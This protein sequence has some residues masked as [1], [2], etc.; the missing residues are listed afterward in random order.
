MNRLYIVTIVLLVVA[1]IFAIQNTSMIALHFLFWSF[2]GSQAFTTILIFTIGFV[3]GWMLE[4]RKV[5][6]KNGQ[7]KTI[8]KKIDEMQKTIGM[9]TPPATK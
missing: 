1:L 8:Q 5:W 7:L 2:Q 6:V 9:M 4:A 3:A